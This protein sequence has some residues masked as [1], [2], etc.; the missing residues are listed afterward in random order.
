MNVRR[1]CMKRRGLHLPSRFNWKLRYPPRNV[2]EVQFPIEEGSGPVKRLSFKA[3]I[4]KRSRSP[5]ESGSEDVR[6]FRETSIICNLDNF[7]NKDGRE[8]E[9]EHLLAVIDWRLVQ[10]LMSGRVVLKEMSSIL[11]CIK[12]V[13]LSTELGNPVK[14]FP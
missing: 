14:L 6:L 13:Q 3:S 1:T 2:N 10:R 11:M 7:P 5:M 9:K 8:P 12:L 4:S